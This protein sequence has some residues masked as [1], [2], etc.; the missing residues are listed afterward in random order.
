MTSDAGRPVSA[1]SHNARE[2]FGAFQLILMVTELSLDSSSPMTAASQGCFIRVFAES[3][4]HAGL[5]TEPACSPLAGGFNLPVGGY[6]RVQPLLDNHRHDT[7]F[8]GM[9][10][11]TVCRIEKQTVVYSPS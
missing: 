7:R 5:A 6:H 11:Q 9:A 10:K 3:Y 2:F 1:P 4:R 8:T